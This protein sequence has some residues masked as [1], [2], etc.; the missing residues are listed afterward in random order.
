MCDNFFFHCQDGCVSPVLALSVNMAA[1]ITQ[2]NRDYQS[3]ILIHREEK[4]LLFP[5]ICKYTQG[6]KVL[7]L[8][9]RIL[10]SVSGSSEL[11]PLHPLET[12]KS[13]YVQSVGKVAN[14][15]LRLSSAHRSFRNANSPGSG[16]VRRVWCQPLPFQHSLR[17]GLP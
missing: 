15:S 4:I 2:N 9:L 11:K 3:D 7:C 5:H 13:C 10:P 17:E 6:L 1:L 8:C 14:S 16:Q 12:D